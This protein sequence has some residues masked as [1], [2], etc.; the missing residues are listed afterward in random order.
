[1]RGEHLIPAYGEVPIT[2]DTLPSIWVEDG[3]R[4]VA[5]QRI[6]QA[7]HGKVAGNQWTCP[8]CDETLGPQFT[9]CWSCGAPRP[10][11]Q[12]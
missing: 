9:E 4:T 6:D 5:R 10:V 11:P 3:D 2:F 8:G 7:L 12:N 1:M